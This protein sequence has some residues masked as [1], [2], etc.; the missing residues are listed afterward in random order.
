MA[1]TSLDEMAASSEQTHRWEKIYT[2][3]RRIPEGKV[4]NYGQIAD[5][6]G[7]PRAARQV[8]YALNALSAERSLDVPWHRVINAKG[9]V[10][11]RADPAS[12][13]LQ[14]ELLE[15]E[16]VGFSKAATVDW[17]RYRWQPE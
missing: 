17:Q 16:G 9:Q 14:R 3:V 5:L 12:E 15:D 6:A 8:G 2:I 4:A 13:N 10:S 1:L 11:Q 7:M